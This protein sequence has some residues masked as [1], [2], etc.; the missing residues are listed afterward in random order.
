MINVLKDIKEGI[1]K[2]TTLNTAWM[3][4]DQVVSVLLFPIAYALTYGVFDREF[5]VITLGVVCMKYLIAIHRKQEQRI[6][7]ERRARYTRL[8]GDEI[9]LDADI[10]ELI[11]KVFRF[12]EDGGRLL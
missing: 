8:K 10:E 7:A 12:E 3:V 4:M 1:R 2:K 5:I 6:D 9:V 11:E